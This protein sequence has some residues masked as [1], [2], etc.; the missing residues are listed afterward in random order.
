MTNRGQSISFRNSNLPT[1]FQIFLF[2]LNIILKTS[3]N[4]QRNWKNCTKNT[5][6][7]TSAVLPLPF[8]LTASSH[9]YIPPSLYPS[10]L[11]FLRILKKKNWGLYRTAWGTLV[12]QSGTKAVSPALEAW[13]LN[14]WTAREVPVLFLLHFKGNCWGSTLQHVYHLLESDVCVCVISWRQNLDT[15]K[16][17]NLK[18]IT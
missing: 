10:I 3:S 14:H 12:P 1:D 2:S 15:A 6:T 17:P 18:R 16:C 4:T 9:L 7:P 5:D 13:S 8:S 11:F